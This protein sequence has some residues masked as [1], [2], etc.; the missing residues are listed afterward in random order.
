MFLPKRKSFVE[1][2]NKKNSYFNPNLKPFQCS[3]KTSHQKGPILKKI[4]MPFIFY[5]P[6]ICIFFGG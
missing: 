3:N 5:I 1:I 4:G 2:N 6:P